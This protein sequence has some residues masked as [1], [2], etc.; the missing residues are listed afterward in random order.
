M[1]FAFVGR[2]QGLGANF[3]FYA[4]L[5]LL[6]TSIGTTILLGATPLQYSLALGVLAVST[7][8]LGQR[9]SRSALTFHGAVY[10]VT[11]AIASGLLASDATLLAGK[12][13]TL[14][15]GMTAAAWAAFAAAALCVLISPSS[16]GG[17]LTAVAALPRMVFAV[18]TV[19]AACGAALLAIGPS[20]AGTPP[21]AGMLATVRTGLLAV[22]AVGLA[23]C[24]RV[25]RWSEFRWLVYPVLALGAL[26]L[27]FEDMRLSQPATLFVALALLGASLV[28][29][30]R[31]VR[32]TG[33]V[34]ETQ[35]E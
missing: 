34:A 4:T 31:L 25:E 12:A 32:R 17:G 16:R 28:L 29:S 33:P 21:D 2:R 15:P 18:L 5:A 20:L 22:A 23:A 24:T 6:L 30:P 26:K 1:A 9:F 35:A 11:A 7:V 13:A 10:C 8:W 19:L 27:L 14:W 3:Y